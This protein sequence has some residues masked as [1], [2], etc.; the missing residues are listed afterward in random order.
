MLCA[1]TTE[2]SY[3]TQIHDYVKAISQSQQLIFN[4]GQPVMPEDYINLADV[5]VS[6]EGSA[7]SY[8][9]FTPAAY[10]NN[11][12]Y[13]KFWHIVYGCNT[14]ATINSTLQQFDQQHAEWLY[15]TDLGM[16]NPYEDLAGNTTWTVELEYIANHTF[17]NTTSTI[18]ATTSSR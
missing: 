7:Q 15:M 16:P 6:F 11:Y 17:T 9:T 5:F 10:T 13:S 8:S 18:N 12:S 4:P 3:Y 2:V 1:D 14:D